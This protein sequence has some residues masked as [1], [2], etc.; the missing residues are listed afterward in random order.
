[1]AELTAT[2][3]AT[4]DSPLLCIE[5]VPN[6]YRPL[7]PEDATIELPIDKGRAAIE[8]TAFTHR[9][10]GKVGGPMAREATEVIIRVTKSEA[11]PVPEGVDDDGRALQA[12]IE[13]RL[14]AYSHV[15]A[16]ML[17][18]LLMF[19]RFV[20]GNPLVHA[21]W[22]ALQPGMLN[23]VWT[24]ER[25]QIIWDRVTSHFA[26]P[27]P[28][29]DL[30]PRCGVKAYGTGEMTELMKVLREGVKPT[31]LEELIGEARDAL[32]VGHLRRAILEL[33]IACEVGVKHRYFQPDSYAE[34][35]YSY[36][37]DKNRVNARVPEFVDGIALRT[38]GHS[39]RVDRP[40]CYR[41][42]DFLFRCRNKVA[43]RGVMSFRDDAG[44]E[45]T[46][47]EGYVARWFASVV[48][49]FEWLDEVCARH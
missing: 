14:P 18:R 31:F 4:L 12:Y 6:V 40:D 19:F 26:D 35:A 46:A 13:T 5:T 34:S 39:L 21:R 16:T 47:H 44:I 42:I 10:H 25:G 49:S 1:M 22:Q 2:F 38:F 7:R 43:H 37:E 45:I 32:A 11:E 48:E 3:R 17:T 30:Y 36:L 9:G 28:A 15:A 24:D 41:D 33:A 29:L 23:P 20:L 27:R 8:L